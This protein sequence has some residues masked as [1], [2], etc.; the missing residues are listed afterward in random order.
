MNTMA[1][2]VAARLVELRQLDADIEV[3]EVAAD[4]SALVRVTPRDELPPFV[5]E[6]PI[7]SYADGP[8]N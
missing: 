5:M 6:M 8:V 7:E 4:G 2:A 1:P 3:L